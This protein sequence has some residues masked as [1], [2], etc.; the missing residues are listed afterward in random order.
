[1][2]SRDP[3]E[4]FPELWKSKQSYFTWLRGNLRKIWNFYPAKLRWKASQLTKP[5]EGYTGRAKK[6]GACYYCKS[7]FAASNLE[8]DHVIPAGKCNSWETS[9]EF[10]M[11][12]LDCNDNWVLA[13][14][15]C[16]KIV[17]NAQNKGISFE[18]SKI[19]KEI[20]ELLK[21]CNKQKVL[22]FLKESGYN[23]SAVSNQQK[24]KAL[25]TEIFR[26]D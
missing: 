10:L 18:E 12:L 3:W 4:V 11:N 21:P 7:M 13:C 14:K 8:V 6:L 25:L 15:P 1:M 16:H 17:N 19:D 2:M 26:K 20:I 9:Y 24:R 5:S 22:A 23:G